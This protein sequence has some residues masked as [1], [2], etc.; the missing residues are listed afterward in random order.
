MFTWHDLLYL[1]ALLIGVLLVVGNALGLSEFGAHP[2]A[3]E[4]GLEPDADG[5]PPAD[6]GILELLGLGRVPLAVLSLTTSLVFG[7]SGLALGPICRALL[8]EHLGP[9]VGLALAGAAAFAGTA[10]LGRLF[11]RFM[12]LSESYA[13][14][15]P[16]LLGLA[17]RVIVCAP[18]GDAIVAVVDDGGAEMRIRARIE[19]GPC[20]AGA[21]VAISGYDPARDLFLVLEVSGHSS[22]PLLTETTTATKERER[23]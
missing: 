6:D 17:G 3:A 7:G 10:A 11:A 15:K 23:A 14:R 8:G 2:D 12:P 18:D 4:P 20:R 21:R 19:T 16:D 22:E 9:W 13:S 1:I 5:G